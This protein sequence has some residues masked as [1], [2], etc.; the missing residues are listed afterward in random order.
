MIYTYNIGPK[1]DKEWEPI[2]NLILGRNHKI[3]R[4]VLRNINRGF[5][6]E[7]NNIKEWAAK[8]RTVA[9][10]DKVIN[11]AVDKGSSSTI[12]PVVS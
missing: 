10:W 9:K 1:E 5:Y 8:N 11:Q 4:Q 6:D 12:L 2:A 7:L 3:L